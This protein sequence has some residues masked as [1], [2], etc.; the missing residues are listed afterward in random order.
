MIMS[1]YERWK[2]Q[3]GWAGDDSKTRSDPWLSNLSGRVETGY[4]ALRTS[5][6]IFY[7]SVYRTDVQRTQIC[8]CQVH[9]SHYMQNGYAYD[10]DLE[11]PNINF[12]NSCTCRFYYY[13]LGN[14]IRPI[15]RPII[16]PLN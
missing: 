11:F 8:K 10:A 1:N 9:T 6:T 14:I 13:L 16:V 4:R 5:E 7:F 2:Y 12:L 3:A 15:N